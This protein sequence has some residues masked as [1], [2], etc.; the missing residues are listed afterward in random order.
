MPSTIPIIYE[1]ERMFAVDKPAG[2]SVHKT[3]AQDPHETLADII[4]RERPSLAGVG[5]DALRPGIV[6]RL[7]KATSGVMVIA[8]DQDAF[9]E[10]KRQFQER[11]VRKDYLALV[12]ST[13]KTASGT[14]DLPL[15][16]VGTRQTTHIE[17]KRDLTVR[18]ASTAYVTEQS[19]KEFT[20]FRVTPRTGRT[21]Q[22]RVHL[23]AIGCPI[24]G[25]PEY[26]P[27]KSPL[28]AGLN[29]MFLHAERLEV[30][31]PAGPRV[32]LEAPLPKALQNVLSALE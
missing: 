9:R 10:L 24:A 2:L 25:D 15:G 22:I 1:D 23:K 21:H 29:R 18:E 11:T 28:P 14:I 5:E 30:T 16:K 17:G 31:S 26:G 8:K 6:H 19:F 7:D 4:L 3:S 20:L 13:P 27:R 12:H 32:A